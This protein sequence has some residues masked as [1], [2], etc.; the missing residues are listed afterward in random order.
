MFAPLRYRDFR[1]LWSAQVFS[2]L[3]DWAG[4]LALAVVVAEQTGSTFL[5]ALVTS[6]SVLPYIGIGQLAAAYVNRFPR[7]TTI[8]ATDLGLAVLFATLA[9]EMLIAPILILA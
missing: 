6:A 1:L 9:I 2:E 3:G 8:I 5:T 7:R 4:R